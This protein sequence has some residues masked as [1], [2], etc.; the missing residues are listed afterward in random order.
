MIEW[1]IGW[2]HFVW[3]VCSKVFAD[4]SDFA[5]EEQH[6]RGSLT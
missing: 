5:A 2:F 6:A 1:M 4:I 3:I